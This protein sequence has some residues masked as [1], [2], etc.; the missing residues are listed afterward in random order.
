[1]I[2]KLFFNII[3]VSCKVDDININNI[4]KIYEM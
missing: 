2:G 1:M 3:N 4:L